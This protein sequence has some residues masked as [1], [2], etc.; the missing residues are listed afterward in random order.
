MAGFI[1]YRNRADSAVLSLSAGSVAPGFPLTN[2][3]VR[4]SD[5]HAR[6]TGAGFHAINMDFGV[7]IAPRFIGLFGTNA[8][9][10]GVIVEVYRSDNGLTW[11][12]EAFGSPAAD[13]SGTPVPNDIKRYGTVATAHRYW[14]VRFIGLASSTTEIARLWVSTAED[15]IEFPEGMDASWSIDVDDRSVGDETGA[16]IYWEDRRARLRRLGFSWTSKTTDKAFGFAD[17]ASSVP[18]VVSSIQALQMA[19]GSTGEVVAAVRTDPLWL[20]RACIRGRFSSGAPRIQHQRG[21]YWDAA[22]V[23]TE[24][25]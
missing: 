1:A 24:E 6:I 7:A 16:G 11:V 19:A 21:A 14:L 25:V 20:H 8:P 22:G 17:G 9:A 18:A 10:P 13:V 5:R 15:M 4:Q 23:V 12:A 3:Q 2:M